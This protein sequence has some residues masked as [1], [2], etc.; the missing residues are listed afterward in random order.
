MR[1]RMVNGGCTRTIF[2]K[3]TLDLEHLRF[4]NWE[5]EEKEARRE[6]EFRE[7]MKEFHKTRKLEDQTP[8]GPSQ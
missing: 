8:D 1:V 3:Q 6:R 5:T 4:L 2:L 7:W